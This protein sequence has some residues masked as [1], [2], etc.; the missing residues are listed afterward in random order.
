MRHLGDIKG[1]GGYV[2]EPV[3]VISGGSPCQDLSVAGKRAGLEGERSS[4]F[5]EQIRVTKELRES[6]RKRGRTDELVRPRY[7]IWENVPG[8]FSS[9]KPKGSDFQIALSEI[10]KI[11]DPTAPDV[12]LPEGGRWTKQGYLY[13]EMGRWSVAWKLHDAQY[14]GVPQRRKRLCVLADLNGLTAA[15][16]LFEPQLERTSESGEPNSIVRYLGRECR[17]EVLAECEGLQRNSEQSESQ[18][19]TIA[20]DTETGVGESD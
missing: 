3:D 20:G 8:A 16:I 10:V 4:L 19:Q 15:E 6:D 1:I 12:P 14:H 18:R 7:F 9:G 11:A 17:P 2:I 5:L 13:D